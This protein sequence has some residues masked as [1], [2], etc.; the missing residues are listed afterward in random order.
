VNVNDVVEEL[1]TLLRREALQSGVSIT[2]ALAPDLPLVMGD[3][4]QL[5][6]VLLNLLMNGLEATKGGGDRREITVTSCR[7]AGDQVHVA[8][9]DTGVGLPPTGADELFKAFFT[10]KPDGTGMG[11]AISRSIIEAHG[12]RLWAASNAD[13]G[14]TF[15]FTLPIAR[16]AHT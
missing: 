13:R 9:T 15:T 14:A 2:A 11:L 1:I 3:R 10:T 6:Q 12:G 5:Q 8:V 7:A 4:V 16:D